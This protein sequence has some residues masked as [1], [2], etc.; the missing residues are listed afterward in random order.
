MI[1]KKFIQLDKITWKLIK[2]FISIISIVVILCFIGSSIFLSK[3]YLQN[4]YKELRTSGE[5]IYLSIKEGQ[6]P[7]NIYVNALLIRDGVVQ[8]LNGKRMGL[9]NNLRSVDFSALSEQGKFVNHAKE[10]FTYYKLSTEFGDIITFEDSQDISQYLR[11]IYLV[12]IAIFLLAL[13]LCIPFISYLGKKFTKPILLLKKASQEIARGDLN[14]KITIN[15]GDEIQE[16]SESLNTMA[17][18]LNKK[19]QLQRDFIANV[20]HDFRTPLSVIRSYSEVI[21]DGLVN[22]EEAKKYSTEIINEV[23]RLNGLVINIM[24][25]SKFQSGKLTLNK[26]VFNIAELLS[27]CRDKFIPVAKQKNIDLILKGEDEEI[28]GDKDFLFRVLFNFID[29]AIKF[30]PRGKSVYLNVS[31]L[32][33]SVKIS[34][35]DEGIGIEKEML[36]DVWTRYYK[37]A[38]S[39]GMGM[40][41]AICSEI[42][43]LHNF[44]YGVESCPNVTTEFYFIAPKEIQ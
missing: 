3:F 8:P 24:E 39:G 27:Q 33:K 35:T 9:M 18:S 16:L 44:K 13:I 15:T 7:D 2:Y 42:L 1:S 32:D 4:K 12:L 38:K 36:K 20:S 28:L 26:T 10:S 21:K 40:G 31:S 30:S 6:S 22:E 34:V 23:D 11:I 17:Y 19:Y 43:K 14:T 25:L 29:N 5:N 41:L 37:H